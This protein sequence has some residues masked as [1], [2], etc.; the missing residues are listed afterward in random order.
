MWNMAMSSAA[1]GVQTEPPAQR[2]TRAAA[3]R[4]DAFRRAEAVLSWL[5]TARWTED[6]YF[7]LP[8]TNRLVE[9]AGGH[10]VVHEMPSLTHQR[11]ARQCFLALYAWNQAR[12]TAAAGEVLFAPYPVRLR[13]GLVREPD[14]VCY[15][16]AH[17]NRLEE[18]R[19]GA[20]DLALEVLSPSTRQLDLTVKLGEYADAGVSE[21]WTVDADERRITVYRLE[22]DA[23]REAGAYVEGDTLT[24]ALLPGFQVPVASLFGAGG[25]PGR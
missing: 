12:G 9:L 11:V 10:L 22:G 20:P 1:S 7:A 2:P 17:R 8:E 5:D 25:G 4:R 15:L 3:A 16:A 23:Y 13:A 18:Q 24:S 6:A 21:Y 19:G 14:V